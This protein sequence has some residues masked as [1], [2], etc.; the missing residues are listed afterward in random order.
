MVNSVTRI[1]VKR[2]LPV[3]AKV[4]KLKK[5]LEDPFRILR[6]IT[7]VS[8]SHKFTATDCFYFKYAF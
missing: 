6:V 5:T 8:M 7:A 4:S 2:G 3:S 1:K